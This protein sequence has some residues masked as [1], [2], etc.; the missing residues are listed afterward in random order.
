M[1]DFDIEPSS[2]VGTEV[3]FTPSWAAYLRM[4]I[5]DNYSNSSRILAMSAVALDPFYVLLS[6]PVSRGIS[7]STN[8]FKPLLPALNNV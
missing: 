4:I 7:N 3:M 5:D 1:H 6:K 2:P 8:Q